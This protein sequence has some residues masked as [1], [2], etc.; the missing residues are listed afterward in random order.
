MFSRLLLE[1]VTSDYK[2]SIRAGTVTLVI[3]QN[4]KRR[5]YAKTGLLEGVP[6]I[7]LNRKL[8]FR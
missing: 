7:E 2:E 3:K 1:E 5:Q 6:T 8:S 4:L